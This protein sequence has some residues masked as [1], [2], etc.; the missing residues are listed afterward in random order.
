MFQRFLSYNFTHVAATLMIAFGVFVCVFPHVIPRFSWVLNYAVQLMLLYLLSGFVFLFFKQPR[1]T[2]ISFGGCLMICFFLKFSLKNNTIDHWR[3]SIL[4]EYRPKSEH[5]EL[6]TGQFN[7]TNSA[8]PSEIASALRTSAA[9]VLSIHEVTPDWSQWLED[10]LQ[11]IYPY[12]HTMV[13][14]GIYGMAIYSRYPIS[15]IDTFYYQTIPNLQ[16][17]VEKDGLDLCIVSVHTE[18]ALNDYARRKLEGHLDML[19]SR[20]DHIEMPLIVMGD[21][22]AVTW[23]EEMQGFMDRTGLSESRSGFMDRKRAFWDVPIDHIFHSHRL[24]CADFTNFS[25][26][27]GNHLGIV[28]SFQI[29][30]LSSHAKKTAN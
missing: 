29:N 8:S 27:A 28:A 23:S 7:L 26:Q 14:I 9:D 21:F 3:K 16:A 15:S 4:D 1:L 24:G 17:C 5:V 19:T 13:D 18:P 30:P 6:K 2:F 22:N 20:I 25:D 10:S 11:F 12:R